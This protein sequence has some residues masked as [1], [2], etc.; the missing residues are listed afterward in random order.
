MKS[1]WN[2]LAG[3]NVS[4]S[5]SVLVALS[6]GLALGLA[7]GQLL[8][9]N[10][11]NV[12]I[13]PKPAVAATPVP[14]HSSVTAPAENRSAGKD[15]VASTP[16]RPLMSSYWVDP[17][18][19]E[20]SHRPF[21]QL[22]SLLAD[23]DRGFFAMPAVDFQS[24]KMELMDDG[25]KLKVSAEVPGVEADR[26]NVTVTGDTVTLK[27]EKEEHPQG[28]ENSAKGGAS[29]ATSYQSFVRSIVLPCRVDSAKAQ[30]SLRNGVLTITAPKCHLAEAEGNTIPI[31][32][33]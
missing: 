32:V 11:E 29:K 15:I 10:A 27:G 25:D 3:S 18:S 5:K 21:S 2:C 16:M 31:H 19:F 13:A 20:M 1:F 8:R 9:S 24:Q 23:A 6:V 30:A 26:L 12:A 7:G 22:A 4:R 33:N 28:A 14:V 17:F